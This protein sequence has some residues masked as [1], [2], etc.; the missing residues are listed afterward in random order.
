[1][2]TFFPRTGSEA[3]WNAAYYR[4][5][6]YFRALRLVNKMHQSQIILQILERAAARHAQDATQ[7]PTVLAM[8]EAV[9][10]MEQWFEG[11]LGSRER[12]G[13]VGLISL[14]AVDAP[15]RWPILFLRDKLP[16]EF[17]REMQDSDVRAGPDLQVSSMVPRPI[18]VSPL[19]DPLHLSGALEKISS[20]SLAI[21]AVVVGLAALSVSLFLISR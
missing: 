10:A 21:L 12:I 11:I 8:E 14:L 3:E 19:L 20:W 5:E 15:A 9:A 4:L 7:N 13:V 17:V 6:D 2:N 18:D 16:L 1:V